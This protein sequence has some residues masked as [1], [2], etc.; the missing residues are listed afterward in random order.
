[1]NRYRV[2]R[3]VVLAAGAMSLA[4]CIGDDSGMDERGDIELLI[5]GEPFDLTADRFQ[6]EHADDY[7]MEF[8]LHEDSEG[9]YN[10]GEEPVTIAEGLDLLPHVTFRVEA[11]G[12]VLM[13]DD[14]TYDTGED[15]VDISAYVNDEPVDIDAH[16]LE[17]G[18]D[19]RVEVETAR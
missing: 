6:A 8:H 5:D 19:I 12:Y 1:M 4:G 13:I 14:E 7:A 18:D 16:E 2:G 10:E 9:W 11:N 3:R 15:G 17:D